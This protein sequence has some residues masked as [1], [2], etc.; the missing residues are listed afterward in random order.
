MKISKRSFIKT[1][2]LTSLGIIPFF[3][4]ANSLKGKVAGI[5]KMEAELV[6]EFVRVAHSDFDQVRKMLEKTPNLLNATQ[7]W[8]DGDFESAIGAAGHMGNKELANYLI[9]KGAR[10]DVFVL[11]MLGK[12]EIVKSWIDLYPNLLQSI[13]P[14]GFTLLHHA[15]KGGDEAAELFEYFSKKGLTETFIPTYKKE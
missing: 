13:G 10:F 1:C 2:G 7:D 11:S 6:E 3:S 9:D 4:Q 5:P 15:K 12:T 8:G 14:H